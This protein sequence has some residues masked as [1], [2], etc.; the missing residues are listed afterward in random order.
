[1]IKYSLRRLLVAIV[2]IS[3]L[4]VGI[5]LLIELSFCVLGDSDKHVW[6]AGSFPDSPFSE[7]DAVTSNGDSSLLTKIGNSSLVLATAYLLVLLIGF[8][9]G[10]LGARFRRFRLPPILAFLFSTLSCAPGFWL[11]IM[12]VQQSVLGWSRPGYADELIAKD[13]SSILYIWHVAVLGILIASGWI[14]WQILTVSELIQKEAS[15]PYVQALF[16]RGYSDESIFYGNVFQRTLPAL[17]RLIDKPLAPMLGVLIA[18]EWAFHF[19][20]AG[21]YLVKS[22]LAGHYGGCLLYTSPSPRDR[23]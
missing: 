18:L 17:T 2:R 10:V 3:G 4:A 1:M 12:L 7:L 19:D 13:A 21:Y 15:S 14:S 23:G 6:L 20:G 8:G 9:W 11:I 16:M 5:I 22:A